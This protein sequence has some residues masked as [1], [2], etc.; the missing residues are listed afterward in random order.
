MANYDELVKEIFDE[1]GSWLKIYDSAF[2]T[3]ADLSG[4][5]GFVQLSIGSY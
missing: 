4:A 5:W 1:E 2:G 3:L